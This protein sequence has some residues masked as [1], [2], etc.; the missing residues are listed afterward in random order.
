MNANQ[1][2]INQADATFQEGIRLIGKG[3]AVIR[4]GCQMLKMAGVTQTETSSIFTESFRKVYPAY[5]FSAPTTNPEEQKRLYD[6]IRKTISNYW[7]GP[8]GQ[9]VT[10]VAPTA[11]P[12]VKTTVPPQALGIAQAPMAAAAALPDALT[13]EQLE[14]LVMNQAAVDPAWAKALA[15]RIL[16]A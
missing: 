12:V 8:V 3:H 15:I 2:T 11:A 5:N 1:M 16:A 9:R 6:N 4:S 13:P 14:E 7:L 10:T